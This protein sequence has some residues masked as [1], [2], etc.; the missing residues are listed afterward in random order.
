MC[1]PMF[2]VV[3]CCRKLK[4]KALLHSLNLGGKKPK[5]REMLM[6]MDDMFNY[7]RHTNDGVK[8]ET[9]VEKCQM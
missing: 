2:W 4:E 6:K 8:C 1:E 7:G 9:V 5:A 3:F